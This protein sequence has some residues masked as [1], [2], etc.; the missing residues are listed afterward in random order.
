MTPQHYFESIGLYPRSLSLGSYAVGLLLSLSLTG[1]SIALVYRH[2]LS[3]TAAILTLVL[4]ACVQLI[5]QLAYFLHLHF[6]A[7]ARP[8][9]YALIFTVLIVGIVVGGTLVVMKNL[10]TRMEMTPSAM[11]A[12]MQKQQGI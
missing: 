7:S 11:E 12:Y 5:V 6:H 3:G 10:N 2:V 1:L 9:V 8:R 4:L